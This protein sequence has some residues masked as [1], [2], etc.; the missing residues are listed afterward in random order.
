MGKSKV[1]AGRKCIDCDFDCQC[2]CQNNIYSLPLEVLERI[3]WYE[4]PVT[5]ASL[6]RTSKFFA[7]IVS[8]FWFSY[9]KRKHLVKK[10]TPL[11]SGWQE[12]E[13]DFYSYG[14]ALKRVND[15][16]QRWRIMA[17]RVYL[18]DKS[19]CVVCRSP[20]ND[21]NQTFLFAEDILLCF[22]CLPHFSIKVTHDLV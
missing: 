9:C 14:K 22:R 20:C 7:S 13:D 1:K 21:T 16:K 10:P 5:L 19:Q 8:E 4:D 18:R 12:T 3:L 6:E 11:C 17:I 2:G 15:D